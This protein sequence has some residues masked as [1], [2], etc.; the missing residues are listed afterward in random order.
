MNT[1]LFYVYHDIEQLCLFPL[2]EYLSQ[3]DMYVQMNEERFKNE[4]DYLNMMASP[5]FESQTMPEEAEGSR[6][7][8]VAVSLGIAF[9]DVYPYLCVTDIKKHLCIC[10]IFVLYEL[11][12]NTE[13]K[14]Q[15]RKNVSQTSP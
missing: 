11:L 4:T 7:V 6:Y 8:N 13:S 14:G 5:N 3:N 1:I 15:N 9:W 2:Q 12:Q 10:I